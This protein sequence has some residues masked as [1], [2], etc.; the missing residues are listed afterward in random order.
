MCSRIFQHGIDT[1]DLSQKYGIKFDSTKNI[2][3]KSK[4]PQG[5]G[6]PLFVV[7][8][9]DHSLHAVD[10]ILGF[11]PDWSKDKRLIFNARVEGN[12]TNMANE[13]YYNGPLKIAESSFFGN[14]FK[15]QRCV[16]PLYAFLETPDMEN[17]NKTFLVKRRNDQPFFV[18]GIFVNQL[19]AQTGL[20]EIRIC[21]LTTAPNKFMHE[22]KKQRAPVLLD[23][24]SLNDWLSVETPIANTLSTCRSKDW[25]EDFIYE[26]QPHTLQIPF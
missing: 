10:A 24:N 18:G 21:I 8:D 15:L 2:N 14:A 23:E 5:P 4:R 26:V 25:S 1:R 11:S 7:V 20:N 22:I 16:V 13:I 19:N 6:S 3:H 9:V 12:S 17:T